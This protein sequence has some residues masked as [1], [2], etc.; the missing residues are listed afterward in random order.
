LLL[1]L[2][3]QLCFCFSSRPH[4]EVQNAILIG[5]FRVWHVLQLFAI[6]EQTLAFECNALKCV[7]IV[8]LA[9]S[10]RS[11]QFFDVGGG[12]RFVPRAKFLR[13]STGKTNLNRMSPRQNIIQMQRA[14]LLDVVVG[15]G[16]AILQLLACEDEALLDRGNTFL[17]LDLG[18]GGVDCVRV[19]KMAMVLPDG[20]LTNIRIPL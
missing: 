5:T 12:E 4:F 20:V 17:V 1:W 19:L 10:A 16:E 14:L 15:E 18:F 13:F 2:Q 11:N 9:T 6:L 8:I 7:I 3:Q